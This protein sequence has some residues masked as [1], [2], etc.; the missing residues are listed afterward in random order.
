MAGTGGIGGLALLAWRGFKAGKAVKNVVHNWRAEPAPTLPRPDVQL[1]PQD[2]NF[3]EV[4]IDYRRASVD[5][6]LAETGRKYPGTIGTL[7]VVKSL[8]NQHLQA[9]GHGSATLHS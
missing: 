1:P 3:V 7:E 6:A 5:Y 8:I 2:V 4:P 9:N